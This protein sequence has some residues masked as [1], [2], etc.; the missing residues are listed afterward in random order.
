MPQ[1]VRDGTR[2]YL[3]GVPKVGFGVAICPF[4]GCL[5][6]CLRYLGHAVSYEY[7]MGVSGGAFRRLWH[8]DDG[9][10][11]DLS[12]FNPEPYRRAFRAIGLAYRTVP[13]ADRAAMVDAIRDSIDRGVPALSFGI[14]GPPEFS[15]ITGYDRHGEV[16]IGYSY[17][18]DSALP[19][20]YEQADWYEHA[21]W[22]GDLGLILIG[23][24]VARP[25]E[26][27][28][29]RDSLQWLVKLARTAVYPGV[30][31]HVC[32][33]AAYQAW[34]DGLEVDADYPAGNAALDPSAKDQMDWQALAGESLRVLEMRTMVHGDQVSMLCDRAA[35]AA[36]LRSMVP[37]APP[38]ATQ[39]LA[40]AELYQQ[41]ADLTPQ[42]WYWGYSMG[43][44]V[45][46]ALTQ[47][48]T[49]CEI[50]QAV[51]RAGEI[52]AQAVEQV[53]AALL[54]LG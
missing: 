22:A 27:E 19:D 44:E 35:G 20:T 8:R 3:Q 52:E 7:L 1:P 37:V 50:A 25:A 4:P 26:S 39:L 34:A 17:F 48:T 29:L 10:N 6:A 49:R 45:G 32:G 14:I 9:G 21:T 43:P 16:L 42:V 53:E 41:V 23:E 13:H 24:P 28:T 51:R 2:V 33:L 47:R 5:H 30:P 40:A 38:V 12:Y 46:Q 11:I 31:D 18:Q 36:Y 54:Q 15:I